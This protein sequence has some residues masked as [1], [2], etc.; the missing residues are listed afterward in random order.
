MS[1][2]LSCRMLLCILLALDAEFELFFVLA[3]FVRHFHFPFTIFKTNFTLVILGWIKQ[4]AENLRPDMGRN[5]PKREGVPSRSRGST[6][7]SGDLQWSR[8]P[9]GESPV[10]NPSGQGAAAIRPVSSAGVSICHPVIVDYF[11]WEHA[12]ASLSLSLRPL[13]ILYILILV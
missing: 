7:H 1:C 4:Q 5:K 2:L 11:A 8:Q 12:K 13:L 3:I 6:Y 10:R 9:R